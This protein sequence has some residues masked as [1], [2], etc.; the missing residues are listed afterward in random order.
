MT[1]I[2]TVDGH[3]LNVNLKKNVSIIYFESFW[4]KIFHFK[5]LSVK[6]KT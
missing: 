4:V 1:I 6:T 5:P 3:H 2:L